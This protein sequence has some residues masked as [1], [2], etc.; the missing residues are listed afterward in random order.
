MKTAPFAFNNEENVRYP[1]ATEREQGYPC[2][3]ADQRLFNGMWHRIESEVGH[4]IDY[5]G[6]IGVDTDLTQ[7]RQAI[8]QLILSALAGLVDTGSAPS[9][10]TSQFILIGQARARLPIFPEILNANAKIVVTAVSPGTIRVPAAVTFQHRGIFPI[11]TVQEDFVTNANKTYHLRWRPAGG[12]L[13]GI[14]LFDL[15]DGVGY[16]VGLAAETDAKFDSTYD[17]ML[18]ARVVTNGSNIATIT[19]LE[20]RNVLRRE[21][22]DAGAMTNP[23][24]NDAVRTINPAWNWARK[25]MFSIHVIDAQTSPVPG[26][27][28]T[29]SGT[30]QNKLHD[31]DW[32]VSET[33]AKSRYGM[34]LKMRRDMALNMDV[35]IQLTA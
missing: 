31:H 19:P 33:I 34:Q 22:I 29:W 24:T 27:N 15:A 17:D 5:A 2:G 21:I 14:A 23:G 26:Q 3:P 6:L 9:I 11:I 32:E 20:N 4:V 1:T 13:Q 30:N 7:L 18:V 25:P 8:Q 10:D 16:N 12:G 35:N 28:T